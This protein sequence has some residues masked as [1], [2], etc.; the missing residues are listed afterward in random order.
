ML[1]AMFSGVSGLQAHQTKLDVSG[2]NIANVDTVG[3]KAGRVTFQDQ[4][5][6]TLRSSAAPSATIGGQN[7]SQVGL[8]VALGTVDT[9]QTQ[10]NLESTGK[11][12][13]MAVQGNGFF[14]VASGSDVYYTRD[15]SF[16]LDSDGV[17]V[18]PAS[19]LKLLGYVADVN[20]KIDT[21]QQV[22]SDSVLKVPI[23]NLTSVKE[24]TSST[25][26][27][28]LNASAALESTKLT[29][30]GDLDAS[31]PP[32]PMTT[33]VYDSQGV[34]HT[35]TMTFTNPQHGT[36]LAAGAGVPANAEQRWDV[37]VTLDGVTK[38][39]QQLYY[40]GGAT[41]KFVFTDSA[42][43]A[44]SLGSTTTLN[45][46][47]STGAANFPLTLDFGSLTA[48]SAV[49]S[50]ANGQG[51]P[52][53]IQSTLLS[54]KGA[55]NLDGTSPIVN[56]TA[57]Y[58]SL[59]NEYTVRTTLSNPTYSPAPGVNVP[60][61]ATQQWDVKIET[62]TVPPSG[63]VTQYDSSVGANA[64]S[65]AYYVPGS[66]FVTADGANPAASLGSTIQMVAGALPP[67]TYNQGLQTGLGFPLTVDLSGLTTTSVT[68]AADGQTG[69][70]PTWNTSLTVYDSLGVGHQVNFTFTRA[71]VGSGAPANA[72]GRWEWT[73][74]EG[75]QKI[76]DSTTAGNNPL[77]FDNAGN[78]IDTGKQTIKIPPSGGNL[79]NGAS[80]MDV[81][82][83][84]GS[85]TQL[86]GSSTVAATT[87][88]G[89]PVGTLQSFTVSD[90][91]LITGIF[92]NGQTR[93]LGQ[94]ALAAFSNPAGLEKEGQNL[95][96]EASN[97]GL[98]QV[99]TPNVSGR[100]KVS[101]GYVEM[102]NVDL[103]T[104]FT[105]LIITERGFQANTKI[106]TMVD[107]MLQDVINLKR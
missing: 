11:S 13:D 50:S 7:P 105:N 48:T 68:S 63:F 4:L 3:F 92:S 5:S 26:A 49:T 84:F 15:G 32:T 12:T 100:G 2:N 99:G 55:V 62:D 51:T 94:I 64:E 72:T 75:G 37:G 96:K 40:V 20:G 102:S 25:F 23:G 28:N 71:L 82:V 21:S 9:L 30:K 34:A 39:T 38:P 6:Q 73:A 80:G 43:P 89:F 90:A 106:I 97:S 47:G 19:G 58:D 57:V 54:L 103:S 69:A 85:L 86:A 65:K 67:G 56:T 24:T 66:G 35:L 107:D 45:V 74:S 87:Q 18:N 70:T 59:G 91:G 36:P 17:M 95:F 46:T 33:T 61:S 83:D 52:G 16:D 31:T 101:T 8:G 53:A 1:Q 104:E 81:S 41:K 27:G 88:D 60:P 76:A 44:N 42:S 22:T 14:M 77:Y 78:L 79:S 10:G 98:A 29:V 93:S